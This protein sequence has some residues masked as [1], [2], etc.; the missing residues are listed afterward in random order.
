MLK[1]GIDADK[2]LKFRYTGSHAAT[3]KAVE[4]GAVDP[5][6]ATKP[7]SAR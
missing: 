4:S 1:V 3:V 2:D 6:P 5:A 7:C